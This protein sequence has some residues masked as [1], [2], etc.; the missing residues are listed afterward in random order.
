MV[1]VTANSKR[2]RAAPVVFGA[3]VLVLAAVLLSLVTA[4]RAHACSEASGGA[5]VT[6]TQPADLAPAPASAELHAGDASHCL[7]V[8]MGGPVC[9]GACGACP[10]AL[11]ATMLDSEPCAAVRPDSPFPD[12]LASAQ[13]GRQFK[14]PRRL[15]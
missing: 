9:A 4:N 2:L 7:A 13:S 5:R 3:A 6:L 14:P 8:H 15:G 1:R 10:A 11:P 12:R